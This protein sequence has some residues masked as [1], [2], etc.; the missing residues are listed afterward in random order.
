MGPR[1]DR[2]RQNESQAEE[3][4]TCHLVLHREPPLDFG[5]F[6]VSL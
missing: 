5:E 1:A 6:F 2:E 3:K 4:T